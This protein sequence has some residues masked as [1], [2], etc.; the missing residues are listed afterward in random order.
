MNTDSAGIRRKIGVEMR[1]R[2]FSE[3]EAESEER[4]G[5]AGGANDGS[6]FTIGSVKTRAWG[7]APAW[8]LAR[9]CQV[10]ITDSPP[11]A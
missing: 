7:K 1:C 6:V 2:V 5:L 10:L 9:E 8:Q 11:P 4:E 3:V